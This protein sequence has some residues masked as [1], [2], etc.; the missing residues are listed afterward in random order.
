M[1]HSQIM[2]RR[3][4][5]SD[6]GSQPFYGSPPALLSQPRLQRAPGLRDSREAERDGGWVLS[7]QVLR[8]PQHRKG[9]SKTD[10]CRGT[11]ESKVKILYLVETNTGLETD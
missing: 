7:G 8:A 4:E 2:N 5:R 10:A 11:T 9:W 3:G 6:L 1:S